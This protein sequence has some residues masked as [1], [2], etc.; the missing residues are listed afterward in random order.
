[1]SQRSGAFDNRKGALMPSNPRIT[2]IS[3]LLGPGAFAFLFCLNGAIDI[4]FFDVRSDRPAHEYAVMLTAGEVVFFIWAFVTNWFAFAALSAWLIISSA[5]LKRAGVP[6]WGLVVM[7]LIFVPVMTF[8]SCKIYGRF[9]LQE[10]GETPPPLLF[11]TAL[12]WEFPLRGFLLIFVLN[13][14][15]VIVCCWLLMRQPRLENHHNAII[16]DA[17]A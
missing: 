8:I 4:Y 13:V 7:A 17:Q 14:A 6:R 16:E 1:V 12:S 2:M 5:L 3:A 10:E 15:A 11:G 9:E